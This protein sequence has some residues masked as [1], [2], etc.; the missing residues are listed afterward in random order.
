MAHQVLR[1]EV[2]PSFDDV[3]AIVEGGELLPDWYDDWVLIERERFRQ[4]RLYALEAL[5][6]DLA[7]VGSYASAVEVGLACVAAEPLRESAHRALIAIHL[8]EGNR[9]EAIRQYRLYRTLVLRELGLTPSAE[10]QSMVKS[11]PVGDET[12]TH[13]R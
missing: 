3:D 12:V 10:L 13:R 2:L 7:A 4:L 8:A 1:H 9:G 6:T 11:L 5:C